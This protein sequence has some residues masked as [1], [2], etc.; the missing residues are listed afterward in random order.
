MKQILFS[1]LVLAGL[2]FSAP[3]LAAGADPTLLSTHDDWKAYRFK[4][5]EHSVCFMSS[6]PVKQEG[7]F[8]KR[9][10]V[11]FFV[12]H[13]SADKVKN[14]VSVAAGYPYKADVPV[15][16]MIDKESFELFTQGEMAWTK[17]QTT[18]DK[19][20]EAL[21]KGE[22]LIVKGVSKR[23][24]E[25]TDTY[26]LKGTKEAYEAMSKECNGA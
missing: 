4:D 2:F 7:P 10:E 15:V 5:G 26:S 12:T 17:D 3:A 22:T 23:G 19:I 24:T 20:A 9:G 8:K 21:Q 1:A 6:Q 25:T 11:F 14:V 18:D 16:V 13:W